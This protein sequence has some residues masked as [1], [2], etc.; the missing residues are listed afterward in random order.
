MNAVWDAT[1]DLN[2]RIGMPYR[3]AVSRLWMQTTTIRPSTL[4]TRGAE[5]ALITAEVDVAAVR[6][7]VSEL[8]GKENEIIMVLHSYGVL[9]GS[10]AL[11][12]LSKNERG[13]EGKAG[14]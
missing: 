14:W 8:V 1:L 6:V 5:P 13:K 10:I 9:P 4:P 7:K 11:K 2:T 3:V 12:G